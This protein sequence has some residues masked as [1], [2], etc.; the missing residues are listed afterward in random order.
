MKKTTAL[1][2]AAMLC[3]CASFPAFAEEKPE[4]KATVEELVNAMT[5]EP[6]RPESAKWKDMIAYVD[7]AVM[8]R[9][10]N[11]EK[12]N[13][14]YDKIVSDKE[15]KILGGKKLTEDEYFSYNNYLQCAFEILGFRTY[16]LV[17]HYHKGDYEWA[18]ITTVGMDIGGKVYMFDARLP[19]TEGFEKERC[20]AVTEKAAKFYLINGIVKRYYTTPYESTAMAGTIDELPREAGK[21]TAYH[22]G[23]EEEYVSRIPDEYKPKIPPQH[24]PWRDAFGRWN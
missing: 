10:T 21:R 22:A 2:L 13:A 23:I 3:V 15:E 16:E 7:E 8:D 20:F 14:V 17:G 6:K 11:F 24:I 5:L 4:K 18:K 19:V 12:M 9:Q 1:I